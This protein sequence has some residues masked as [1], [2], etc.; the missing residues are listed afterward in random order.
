MP[1]AIRGAKQFI[2]DA[3]REALPLGA[4]HG[5]ANPMHGWS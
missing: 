1:A 2:T 4:G 3:I 5:P